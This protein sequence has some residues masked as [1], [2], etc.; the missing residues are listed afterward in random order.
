[1]NF[2]ISCIWYNVDIYMLLTPKIILEHLNCD[3]FLE[4]VYVKLNENVYNILYKDNIQVNI[5][6]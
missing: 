4:K 5:S 1:M 6:I 2:R 3:I